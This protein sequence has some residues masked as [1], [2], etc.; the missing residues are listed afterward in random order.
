MTADK[1]SQAQRV[2]DIFGGIAKL[3]QSLARAGKWRDRSVIYR[4]T[5]KRDD[6]GNGTNGVVP[7]QAMADIAHAARLD[8]ILLPQ[9]VFDP[10]EL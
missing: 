1:R 10:R 5:Q 8:G 2:I 7:T 9:S 4:W 3:Q 6:H